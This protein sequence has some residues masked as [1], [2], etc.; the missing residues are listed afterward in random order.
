[1][2]VANQQF[3]SDNNVSIGGEMKS[4]W[5]IVVGVVLVAVCSVAQDGTASK[6]QPAHSSAAKTEAAPAA[7]AAGKEPGAALASKPEA[8][9]AT[10]LSE[11]DRRGYA[12]G[13]QFG[14]DLMRQGVEANPHRVMQGMLDAITGGK[15][16]LSMDEINTILVGIQKEQREN[17]LLAMRETAEKNKRDGEAFLA[18]NKSKEGVVSLPSGLQYKVLK[19]GE[20]KKPTIDDKVV[21]NYRGTLL[22]GTEIDSSYKRNEPS[23]FPLKGVIRGW[24]EV[25]QLMPVGSKWQII[26]PPDL[27]YGDRGSSNIGPNTT[28]IFEVE[29][30]SILDKSQEKPQA[31]AAKPQGTS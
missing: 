29:L 11:A 5:M 6:K 26:L 16:L 12:L 23:T 13:V 27:A 24:T 19:A 4:R 25:L 9:S 2:L 8:K 10:Q 28:L 21:C 20:G 3:A 30:I 14:S 17:V 22:D 18:A 7:A 31:A 1:M 15:L